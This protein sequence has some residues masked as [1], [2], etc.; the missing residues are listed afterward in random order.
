MA[1]RNPSISAVGFLDD[2]VPGSDDAD[3]MNRTVAA[4]GAT[5]LAT[6]LVPTMAEV[7]A[8]NVA[9]GTAPDSAP[10]TAPNSAASHAHAPTLSAH[11]PRSST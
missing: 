3:L 11:A 4:I 6:G 5:G 2:V 7:A 8:P 10:D 1:D 9:L